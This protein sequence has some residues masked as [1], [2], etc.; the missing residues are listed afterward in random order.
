MVFGYILFIFINKKQRIICDLGFNKILFFSFG[1]IF[2]FVSLFFSTY[3]TY[4]SCSLYFSIKHI[5]IISVILILY[6][7]IILGYELGTIDINDEKYKMVSSVSDSLLSIDLEVS[8]SS[9][10]NLRTINSFVSIPSMD[11]INE[12]KLTIGNTELNK[13]NHENLRNSIIF[14]NLKKGRENSSTSSIDSND[15]IDF[16]KNIFMYKNICKTVQMNDG[17]SSRKS[18]NDERPNTG[19]NKKQCNIDSKM[20]REIDKKMKSFKRNVKNAHNLYIE[21]IALYSI[22]ILCTIF[23]FVYYKFKENPDY[24]ANFVQSYDGKWYYKCTLENIDIIY[25]SLE[26]FLL[27]LIILKGKTIMSYEGVFICT[28]YINY[29]SIIGVVLGPLVNV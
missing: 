7:Y 20:K 3:S 16:R 17:F 11:S 2:F 22:N 4:L 25:N 13:D 24:E 10:S 9:L 1:I 23:L 29:S 12:N 21:I 28:K 6:I 27:G 15:S 26:L 19:T 18:S 14:K 5:G 8:N